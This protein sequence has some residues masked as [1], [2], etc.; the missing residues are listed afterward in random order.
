MT[1]LFFLKRKTIAFIVLL[2]LII[3]CQAQLPV[4]NLNDILRI[5]F[6]WIPNT[7]LRSEDIVY[8]M[9]NPIQIRNWVEIL[10]DSIV[11]DKKELL[12]LYLIEGQYLFKIHYN[13]HESKTLEVF[14]DG[15]YIT[16]SLETIYYKNLRIY[17][18]TQQLLFFLLINDGVKM[19]S[20][21]K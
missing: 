5:E 14:G 9:E 1:N 21:G 18:Y 20:L 3:N 6:I 19:E 8:V 11:I 17:Y 7:K 12:F 16:D 15:S 10:N 13:N 4:E 2:F